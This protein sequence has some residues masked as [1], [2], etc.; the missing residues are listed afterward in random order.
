MGKGR[1]SQLV[2]SRS[3]YFPTINSCQQRA[4]RQGVSGV[5]FTDCSNLAGRRGP[6]AEYLHS[7]SAEHRLSRGGVGRTEPSW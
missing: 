1:S 4:G 7:E 3:S 6:G 2:V 5:S